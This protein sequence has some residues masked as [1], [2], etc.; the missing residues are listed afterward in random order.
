MEQ[1]SQGAMLVPLQWAGASLAR[2]LRAILLQD[3]VLCL[4]DTAVLNYGRRGIGVQEW[5]S[6]M[7]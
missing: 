2:L 4:V 7:K 6:G 1:V 3:L 5:W